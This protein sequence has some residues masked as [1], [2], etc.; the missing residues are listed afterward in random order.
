M[1]RFAVVIAAVALTLSATAHA[2]EE[3]HPAPQQEADWAIG[4]GVYTIAAYYPCYVGTGT[5][6][7][8]YSA[9]LT[10]LG[11]PG[12][13][14]DSRGRGVWR[15]L[16][17]GA[18]IAILIVAAAIVAISIRK[19]LPAVDSISPGVGSAYGGTAVTIVWPSSDVV[20][21]TWQPIW[22][23]RRAVTPRA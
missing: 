21:A 18:V 12:A 2:E 7:S 3:A 10:R 15:R 4:A 1:K 14:P 16:G 20:T 9:S 6:A 19:P 22:P 5:S 11:G 8:D 23:R 17:P 13:G